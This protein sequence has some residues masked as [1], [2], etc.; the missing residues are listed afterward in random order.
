MPSQEC[1]KQHPIM[2]PGKSGRQGG[3]GGRR[4]QGHV[5]HRGDAGHDDEGELEV[6]GA[7]SN[8]RSGDWEHGCGWSL[9]S[10]RERESEDNLERNALENRSES[11]A[12]AMERGW[13]IFGLRSQSRGDRPRRIGGGGAKVEISA[14]RRWKP[15]RNN[16]KESND[17][18]K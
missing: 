11:C 5:R 3:R 17:G 6:V 8:K 7:K 16:I 1:A 15:T 12:S 18:R 2:D 10:F 14:T 9:P 4:E 13:S